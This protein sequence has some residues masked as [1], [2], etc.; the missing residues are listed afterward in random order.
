MHQR[1]VL[2]WFG[3]ME[4]DPCVSGGCLNA[5]RDSGGGSRGGLVVLLRADHVR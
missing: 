3:G 5:K 2:Y 4:R 1:E